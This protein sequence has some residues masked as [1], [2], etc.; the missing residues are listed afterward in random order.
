MIQQ[1]LIIAV[2]VGTPLF[3]LWLTYKYSFLSKIG[4]MIIAYIIGCLIGLSGLI[5]PTDEVRSLQT[6]I[7][8]ATIPFAIPLMLF[9]SNVKSW[10]SLAPSFV[11]SLIFGV[12]GCIAAVFLGF[13]LFGLENPERFS[14]IGGM[15][16]GKYTGGDANLASLKIALD[17]DDL[18][19]LQVNTYSILVSA[20]YLIFVIVFGQRVLNVILPRFAAKNADNKRDSSVEP[21]LENHD[22]ELFY[23]L[24]RRDNMPHLFRALGLTVLIVAVGAGIALLCPKEM[25]QAVFILVISLLSVLASLHRKVRNT[26][27]TFELGTYFILV[28]SMAVASQ[29]NVDMFRN[30]DLTFFWY[31]MLV[32]LGALFV[33]VLLSAIFRVDTDTTL[34]TSISLI[35]SPPFVP[36]ISSALKNKTIIGPGIAVGLIG[37]ASGTYI[38]FTVSKVLLYSFC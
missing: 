32:T 23:G 28:F 9:S 16:I 7:A 3:I 25:F 2:C 30:I 24:F 12:L 15:L 37:Y 34:T 8:S 19:Y 36:V 4:C 29:V 20:L 18:T 35:C 6:T 10:A 1:I 26:L 33:H 11:K 17:V 5:E 13:Y 21:T 14:A 38:G 22:G 31:T 27:R